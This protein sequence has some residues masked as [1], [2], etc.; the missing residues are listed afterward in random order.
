MA[1]PSKT[2]L[3]DLRGI[4]AKIDPS[5]QLVSNEVGPVLSAFLYHTQYGED[6]V[7]AADTGADEVSKLLSPAPPAEAPTDAEGQG[8][9]PA[10][11][12]TANEVNELRAQLQH[13]QQ[14]IATSQQTQVEHEPGAP[15]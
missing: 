14:Q 6:L 5:L 7:K 11:G 9:A 3:D 15:E 4:A 1:E 10:S 12:A 13:L 8:Q 2:F